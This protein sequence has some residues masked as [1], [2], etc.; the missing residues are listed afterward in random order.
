[1][2][3]DQKRKKIPFMEDS[4]SFNS[5]LWQPVLLL[6]IVNSSWRKKTSFNVISHL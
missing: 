3:P 2:E 4:N 5:C 1:M 6:V